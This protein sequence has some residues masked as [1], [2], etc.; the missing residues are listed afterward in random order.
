MPYSFSITYS[1]EAAVGRLGNVIRQEQENEQ[2]MATKAKFPKTSRPRGA[3]GDLV[4]DETASKALQ[5]SD[6]TTG[7]LSKQAKEH[8]VKN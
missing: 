1:T 7:A 4:V 5:K 6:G 8:G 3:L 2:S